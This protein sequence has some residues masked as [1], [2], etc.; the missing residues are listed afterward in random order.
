MGYNV[1]GR[2]SSVL[3]RGLLADPADRVRGHRR[4]WL[5]EHVGR[6]IRH[7]LFPQVR[8]HRAARR[9]VQD[10]L[11]VGHD[12]HLVHGLEVLLRDRASRRLG[13]GRPHVQD[14]G[15]EASAT[16]R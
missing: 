2:S 6:C 1:G 10:L 3:V 5:R 8:V 7:A 15:V 12:R 14:N 11:R 4:R 9:D 16:R 13:C